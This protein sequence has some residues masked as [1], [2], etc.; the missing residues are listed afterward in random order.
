MDGM[1]AH[2]SLAIEGMTCAACSARVTRVLERVPG[3]A[4]AQVN[5]AT[6][7]AEITGSAPLS[8][9]LDAVADAGYAAQPWRA[10]AE[11]AGAQDAEARAL[12]RDATLALLLAAP[13]LL[14]EMGGHVIPAVH[15]WV[16]ATLGHAT[17]HLVQGL[18]ATAILA[19]PGWR[20]FRLGAASLALRAPDMNALVAIGAGA[21][22]LYSVVSLALDAHAPVYFE[23]AGVIVALVL[24]GR[25]LE[26]R[27]RGRAGAAIRGLT[28]LAPRSAR[29][30]TGD[31]AEEVP[32]EALRVGDLL[33]IRPGERIPVDGRVTQGESHVDESMFTG[34]PMP[35]ARGAGD[36]VLGGSVNRH[37]ALTVR[38]ERIGAD[39]LLAGIVR[40][41]E[42]AEGARM[43]IQALVDRITLVFVPAVLVLAAATFAVWL[44]AGGGFAAALM[45]A[46][47]V[48]IIACPCAMGLATPISVMVGMGRAARLGVLFREG[49]ALQRL[50]GAQRVAF[51]KTGTLTEGH[52]E[53]AAVLPLPGHDGPALLRLVAAVEAGSEHPIARAILAA[54]P[55][56]PP[57][58][59]F[60]IALG[61]G[62]AAR[63]EGRLV[64]AGSATFL[65]AEGVDPGA[66]E[67]QAAERAGLGETPVLVALDGAAA[68]IVTVADPVRATTPEAL[69][70]LAA[71][72]L[73]ALM[74]TGDHAATAAAVAGRLG[75]AEHRAG[76]LPADKLA[77]LREAPG[78]VFVGDGIN[79]AP[80]LAAADV[81]IA[82]ATGTDIAMESAAVVLMQGDLRGV[83][84]AVRIAR[85]TLANIR[86]NLV[87][88]FGYNVALV[89]VAAGVLVPFGGPALSP[90]LAAAAMG[91]SSLFVVGNALRLRGVGR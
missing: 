10:A 72:G 12:G 13:L 17:S 42:Q 19:G 40:M 84:A 25:W 75:I 78:T 15:A 14:L 31:N 36:P 80:A 29:R 62:A 9:L 16:G 87:W 81:G 52:P 79:D 27:A 91:L 1:T 63:V 85:A 68:G 38:A 77:A 46:V 43:P 22:W 56:P 83:A 73:P 54:V 4:G 34:E 7:R 86:Q 32:L 26:A 53:L 3:V 71:L 50:A 48:L 18:L 24:L 88:A 44:A 66:L 70:A 60:R 90:M 6:G 28:E 89:P 21:A 41:V 65:R 30:I 82:L 61:Q 39:T 20:F 76:L 35:V 67:A 11:R 51:D 55:T 69:R 59:G 33:L 23:S 74:L 5:F 47:A 2:T 37:G 64:L 57:A 58:E 45:H 8:A 49:E